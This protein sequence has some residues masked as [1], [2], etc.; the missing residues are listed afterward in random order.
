MT[1]LTTKGHF[2][3]GDKKKINVVLFLS[4]VKQ[5][6]L[7]REFF[8]MLNLL[9]DINNINFVYKSHPRLFFDIDKGYNASNINS[10]QLSAWADVS[11]LFGSSIAIH[12]LLDNVPIIVPS[13]VHTN[14]TI[15]EKYKICITAKDIGELET[16][17]SNNT[18]DEIRN[19]IDNTKVERFL[20]KYLDS[21]KDYEQ[22]MQEYYE[23]MVSNKLFK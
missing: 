9:S 8:D 3:F 2:D 11:I 13:F 19:L 18:K 22:I 17:L 15:L 20:N 21:H 1:Y 6:V 12:L 23:A 4:R 14:S 5:N 10:F 16:L 7:E